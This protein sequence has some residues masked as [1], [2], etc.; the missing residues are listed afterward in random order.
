MNP[1]SRIK[2]YSSLKQKKFREKENKFLIEGIHLIEECLKSDYHIETVFICESLLK[3]RIDSVSASIAQKKIPLV[4]LKNKQFLKL[5]D[6]ENPQ[7]II[8]VVEK[9][10][11]GKIDYSAS[12]L[13]VALDGI[14]DPGNLG[15][16]IRT[17]H[18]FGVDNLL[19]S[20]HS[21]DL[22]NPKVVRSTQGS[23]FHINIFENIDLTGELRILNGLGFNVIVLDVNADAVLEIKPVQDKNVLV[24]G[25][26][27]EGISEELSGSSYSRFKIKGYSDCESLNLAVSCGIALNILRK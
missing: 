8:A 5:S 17:C 21:V 10:S 24:F 11:P 2:Y 4:Y 23:V 25:N 22:Y 9:K 27:S 12:M 18:W 26:E 7:G 13:V 16:I 6:T 14:S 20:A 1:E 3:S 19:L 15:T